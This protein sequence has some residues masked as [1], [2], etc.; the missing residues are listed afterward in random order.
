MLLDPDVDR[1]GSLVQ[2]R[3][4]FALCPDEHDEV[5][6]TKDHVVFVVLSGSRAPRR[7]T[8]ARRNLSASSDLSGQ[9]LVGPLS[10]CFVCKNKACDLSIAGQT[11][12]PLLNS[13]R[14]LKCYSDG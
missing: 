2:F 7:F 13:P 6:P 1:L 14:V 3:M 4:V 9:G 8:E 11:Y 10:V 5:V 12:R